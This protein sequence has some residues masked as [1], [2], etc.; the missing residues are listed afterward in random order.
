MKRYIKASAFD[1]NAVV[2]G[3]SWEELLKNLYQE[4]HMTIAPDY[5]NNPQ[6]H[7]FIV[8]ADRNQYVAEVTKYYKGD[9]ELRME[10]VHPTG[11]RYRLEIE[12]V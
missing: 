6:K 2:K 4:H 3:D 9:Y 11:K 5:E 1:K 7:V 10:N 12:E 8:D